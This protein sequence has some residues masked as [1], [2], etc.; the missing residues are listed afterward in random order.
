MREGDRD[1]WDA[2]IRHCEPFLRDYLRPVG[3]GTDAED[4]VQDVLTKLPTIVEQ[5]DDERPFWPYLRRIARN[6]LA[7]FRRWSDRLTL[8]P[9]STLD[10]F[11]DPKSGPS[12]EVARDDGQA[13]RRLL[14]RARYHVSERDV[15]AF[16]LTELQGYSAKE[17]AGVLGA[18][19]RA[20]Y[21]GRRKVLEALRGIA[22]RTLRPPAPIAPV[23]DARP[24]LA[25]A[26]R[27]V[28][29]WV[30]TRPSFRL[31]ELWERF[32]D[33]D[34]LD[35]YE[36]VDVLVRAGVLQRWLR[37]RGSDGR[38]SGPYRDLDEVPADRAGGEVLSEFV[39]GGA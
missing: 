14:M 32:G 11:E 21:S 17:A 7:D 13:V 5:Y 19:V 9:N 12:S 39:L 25:G 35:L 33:L 4:L 38:V 1:A 2:L 6:A 30:R 31:E 37:V 8:L 3:Q 16:C 27:P 36:S 22:D 24:E 26:L 10:R 18:K 28:W 29:D 23:V 34:P 20:V 15:R